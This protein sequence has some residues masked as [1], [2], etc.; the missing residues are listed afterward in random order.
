FIWALAIRTPSDVHL[1]LIAETPNRGIIYMIRFARLALAVFFIGF[2]LH[3]FFSLSTGIVFTT[4]ILVLLI[5]FSKRIQAFYSKL[6]KR[7]FTNLN[8]REIETS[9][10]NRTE[11]APWDAHIVPL[12][13]PPNASCI[14]KT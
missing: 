12:V 8:Q 14:G 13:V 7:F 4:L 2:L 10:I 11:L 5:A 6:E 9:R 3:R 1:K